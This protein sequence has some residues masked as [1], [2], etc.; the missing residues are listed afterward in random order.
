M[1]ISQVKTA[2]KIADVE[3]IE[4]STKLNFNYLKNLKDENNNSLPQ[5]ILTENVARVYLIVVDGEIKKIGGSQDKG[6]I[7]GTLSIY[8]DGGV[9]GRPSIRSFGIWY[10]LYHTILQGKKIEFYMIFQENFEKDI[11][12]LFGYHKIKNASISYKFI[13]E[14]CNKDY[15]AFENSKYPDWNVQ[16]QGMDWPEDIKNLHAEI[17]KNA[18]TRDK[19]IIRQEVKFNR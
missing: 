8:K 9:K 3:F 12:S 18:Q 6:G 7:K 2:F 11:K 4:G 16:E 15:L 13:E 14:C 5:S 17:Q 1:R 10:F 19:K